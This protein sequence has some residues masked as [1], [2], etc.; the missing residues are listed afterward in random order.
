MTDNQPR[1]TTA[2]LRREVDE[3]KQLARIHA[4]EEAAAYH[5]DL[6]RQHEVGYESQFHESMVN[7]HRG[8]AHAIRA[9]MRREAA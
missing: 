1:Y 2:R 6:A 4:L 8:S 5:D 9:M 3:A 7:T